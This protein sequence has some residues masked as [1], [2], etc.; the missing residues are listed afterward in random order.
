MASVA[1]LAITGG[2]LLRT[3][4]SLV[5][6]S[7]WS[8][9]GWRT[10]VDEA[11]APAALMALV[12]AVGLGVWV[13]VATVGTAGYLARLLRARTLVGVVDR[14]TL[15]ALRRAT[16]TVAAASLGLLGGPAAWAQTSAG[17]MGGPVLVNLGADATA[18]DADAPL[19]VRLSPF[20]SRSGASSGVSDLD[21]RS[22]AEAKPGVPDLDDR[23]GTGALPPDPGRQPTP[24][25][26]TVGPGESFWSRAERLAPG[27][28]VGAYWRELIEVNRDRLADPANPDLIFPGQQF[29]LPG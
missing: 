19:M 11:G 23:S 18:V 9:G 27:E 20:D 29:R 16:A 25:I 1:V 24:E 5:L 15:P 10:W 13:Y 28:E 6:G 14:I 12:R 21:H 26:W 3:G 2:V 8:P 7:G 4:D 22:W 17:P